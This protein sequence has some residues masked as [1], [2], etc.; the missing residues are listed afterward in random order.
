VVL[1]G[2][3]AI[4]NPS[5]VCKSIKTADCKVKLLLCLIKHHHKDVYGSGG[6]DPCILTLA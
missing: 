2:V 6:I 5:I 3:N 4:P 1:I